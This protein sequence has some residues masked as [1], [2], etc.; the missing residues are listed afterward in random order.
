MDPESGHNG[1][2]QPGTG[3]ER[4]QQSTWSRGCGQPEDR[5]YPERRPVSSAAASSCSSWTE[6]TEAGP[7]NHMGHGVW[8][9]GEPSQPVQGIVS[10]QKHAL[11]S[12]SVC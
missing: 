3:P 5:S 8:L 2:V 10:V 1:D 11:S 7:L 9:C 4:P 6:G 12:H